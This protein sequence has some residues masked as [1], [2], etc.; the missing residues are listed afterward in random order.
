M[1][2]QLISSPHSFLL[3]TA[4]LVTAASPAKHRISEMKKT[5]VHSLGWREDI[6][7]VRCWCDGGVNTCI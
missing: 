5:L 4:G 6:K 3:Q 1:I 7:A 2:A